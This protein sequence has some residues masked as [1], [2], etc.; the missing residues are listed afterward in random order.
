MYYTLG[1]NFLASV[2]LSI[3]PEKHQLSKV[4]ES[5]TFDFEYTGELSASNRKLSGISVSEA[6][7]KVTVR[8]TRNSLDRLIFGLMGLCARLPNLPSM[9]LL[10]QL[11]NAYKVQ[12][13]A[14]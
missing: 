5:Y 10:F 8:N 14:F 1:K 4:I 3:I 6:S 9:S 13:T 2:Q 7:R 11:A 12:R